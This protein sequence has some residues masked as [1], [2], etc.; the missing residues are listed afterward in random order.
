L[1]VSPDREKLA[2]STHHVEKFAIGLG[3]FHLLQN[4]FHRLDLVHV[5]QELAQN[6]GLLQNFWL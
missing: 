5:V 1:A 4:H 2:T 3:G 6:A